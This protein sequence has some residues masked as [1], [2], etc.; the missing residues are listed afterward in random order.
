MACDLTYG[1]SKT[2]DERKALM[3]ALI[4]ACVSVCIECTR[5]FVTVHFDSYF[6]IRPFRI[7]PADVEQVHN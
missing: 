6:S 1:F 7:I 5:L 2:P 4:R 3:C